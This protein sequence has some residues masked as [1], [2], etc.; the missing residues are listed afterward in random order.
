VSVWVFFAKNASLDSIL[1]ISV[2]RG[3]AAPLSLITDCSVV[4]DFAGLDV[5]NANAV[6]DSTK[7]ASEFNQ[8]GGAAFLQNK[9]WGVQLFILLGPSSATGGSP[10]WDVKYSTCSVSST[11]VPGSW[12]SAYYYANTGKIVTPPTPGSGTCN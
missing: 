7:V 4:K 1:I 5:I 11:A 10:I 3:H 2:V 9:T 12:L 8:D 6:V